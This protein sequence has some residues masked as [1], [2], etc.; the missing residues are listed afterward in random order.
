MLQQKY[1]G[2]LRDCYKQFY[3]SKLDNT[4]EM[5]KFIGTYILP[6][7]NHEELE[8]LIK[9]YQTII[10]KEVESVIKNLQTNKNPR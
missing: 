9:Q 2:L 10:S 6:K 3:D 8:N 4:K 1:K 7:L 5:S